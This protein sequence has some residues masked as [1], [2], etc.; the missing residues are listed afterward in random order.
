MSSSVMFVFKTDSVRVNSVS[1][2]TDET[3]TQSNTQEK[4]TSGIKG[5]FNKIFKKN[6][7]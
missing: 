1:E 2:S 7:G 4:E 6:E 5:F 3:T